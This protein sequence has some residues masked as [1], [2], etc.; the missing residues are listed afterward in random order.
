MREKERKKSHNKLKEKI[1][2]VRY[3]PYEKFLKKKKR[4]RKNEEGDDAINQ[5]KGNFRK[6]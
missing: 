1:Y 2:H 4:K 3:S 5:S 6:M